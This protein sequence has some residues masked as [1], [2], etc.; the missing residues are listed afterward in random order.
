MC[1]IIFLPA[2]FSYTALNQWLNNNYLQLNPDKTETLIIAL[3]SAVSHIKQQLSDLDLLQKR[4]LR[5]LG[6]IFDYAFSLEHN[7]PS[8]K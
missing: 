5:N 4:S 1:F 7:L 2:I 3:D 8:Y 6:V